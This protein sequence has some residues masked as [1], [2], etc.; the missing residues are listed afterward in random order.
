MVVRMASPVS[1]K[2]DAASWHGSPHAGLSFPAEPLTSVL[3]ISPECQDEA[4]SLSRNG[5]QLKEDL[6][7]A[8]D[9]LAPSE[10]EVFSVRF[11]G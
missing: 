4:T 2:S 9:F 1:A 6:C 8:E 7:I 11:V 5:K 3:A 10:R